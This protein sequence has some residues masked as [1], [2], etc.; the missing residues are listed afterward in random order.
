MSQ[1]TYFLDDAQAPAWPWRLGWWEEENL[2]MKQGNRQL[3]AGPEPEKFQFSAPRVCSWSSDC[4]LLSLSTEY[5]SQCCP[6]LTGYPRPRL[7]DRARA[8]RSSVKNGYEVYG[9]WDKK[10]FPGA[11]REEFRA[12]ASPW[13]VVLQ[14]FA[15]HVFHSCPSTMLNHARSSNSGH[16]RIKADDMSA[17]SCPQEGPRCCGGTWWAAAY[18]R[19]SLP[20]AQA[21]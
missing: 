14:Y 7:L 2:W 20:I 6:R 8:G 4:H 13:L 3:L 17:V 16:Q 19:C 10:V 18:R 11:M 15:M 5:L 1:T 9:N 21:D 12:T